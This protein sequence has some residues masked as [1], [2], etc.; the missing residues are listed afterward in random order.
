M[1]SVAVSA[2]RNA[3]AA[4]DVGSARS[5]KAMRGL[6]W[7]RAADLLGCRGTGDPGGGFDEAGSGDGGAS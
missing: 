6:S 2:R 7:I 3:S 4:R 1:A 5:Q